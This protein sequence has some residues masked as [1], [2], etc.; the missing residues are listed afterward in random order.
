MHL[1]LLPAK[2]CAQLVDR[3]GHR[4]AAYPPG[5]RAGCQQRSG[6]D[7]TQDE[8][9][10]PGGQAPDGVRKTPGD[11]KVVEHPVQGRPERAARYAAPHAQAAAQGD[12]QGLQYVDSVSEKIHKS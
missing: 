7:E 11:Q 12:H 2:R 5:R 10:R 1:S 6:N 4:Q 3:F 9:Q 8:G